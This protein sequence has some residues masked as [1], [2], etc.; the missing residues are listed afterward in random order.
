[1]SDF[2]VFFLMLILIVINRFLKKKIW[3]IINNIILAAVFLLFVLDIFTMYFFQSRLSI[4]DLLQFMEPSV[5]QFSSWMIGGF[6]LF[7]VVGIL[8]FLFVQSKT[9]K[10]NQRLFLSG[11]LLVFAIACV[12]TSIYASAGFSFPDNILSINYTALRQALSPGG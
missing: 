10:K 7:F 2:F 4:L 8:V 9:F 1:V 3:R 12:L 11:G 5:W 6:V